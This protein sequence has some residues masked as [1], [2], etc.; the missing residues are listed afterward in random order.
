MGAGQLREGDADLLLRVVLDSYDDDPGEGVPWALMQGLL[1]LVACDVVTYQHHDAVGRFTRLYQHLTSDGE[2]LG[3]WGQTAPD[4]EDEAFWDVFWRSSCSWPQRSGDLQS[5]TLLRDHLPT[6]RARLADPMLR[7]LLRDVQDKAVLSLPAPPGQVRRFVLFRDHDM[8]FTERDRQ[9]LGLLRPHLL[10]LTATVQMLRGRDPELTPREWEVL[11]M[12][13]S[14]LSTAHVARA[15]VLSPA[16]VRKHVENIRARLG[17]HS[18]AAAVAIAMPRA[19][20][21]FDAQPLTEP[22]P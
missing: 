13:A 7:D 20:V 9:V 15:L 18:A 14:G 22:P 4:P 17:V 6:R 19:P 10:E 3:P 1:S 16:T 12:L 8:P 5:V 21:S 11:R 2:R